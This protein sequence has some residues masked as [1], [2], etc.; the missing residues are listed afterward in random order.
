MR[1]IDLNCDVG[2]GVGDDVQIIP[3][4]TSVNVACGFH[5]GGP[6]VIRRTVRIARQHGVAVGAH[7][8][9]PDRAGFGRR[10]LGASPE[11]VRDDVTYQ[12]GALWAFCQAEGVRLTHVKPH[13]ALYNT[14]AQDRA[15][16]LAI[17]EAT[18][19]VDPALIVVCLA[20]SPMAEV[21]RGIGVPFAEEAFADRAYMATGVLAPRG[22]P[23][24]VIR[25]PEKVAERVSLMIRER[26]VIAIDGTV[27]PIDPGTICV[28]GDTPGAA[29]LVAAI[30]A[31]LTAE[32]ISLKP[33]ARPA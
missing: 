19:A 29:Q 3:L 27:I 15:L 10:F 33:L 22:T 6:D 28:H 13:G 8:S 11:E 31:R 21:A 23:G 32:G 17:C 25:D 26:R 18:R 20:R 7:P 4:V 30:R 24:A 14:A 2:E 16:A 1:A 9:Y 12:I 5:A